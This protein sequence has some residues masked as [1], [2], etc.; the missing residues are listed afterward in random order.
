MCVQMLKHGEY[1]SGVRQ[2]NIVQHALWF[3]QQ[4]M[5]NNSAQTNKL[6]LNIGR[7]D[8]RWLHCTVSTFS[9]NLLC[10]L[11]ISVLRSA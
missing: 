10:V 2:E 4:I 11:F 7:R 6:F 1:R 8:V 5:S 3:L 9:R